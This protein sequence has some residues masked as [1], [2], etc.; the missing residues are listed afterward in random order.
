MKKIAFVLAAVVMCGGCVCE[1]NC[2][3]KK[4]PVA[5]HVV[6]I[7]VDGLGARWIPWDKMPNLSKL[8][9]D[10]LYAVGRDNYPTSSAINWA[11]V[12][13]G[14]VVEVHGYRNWNSE[15]PDVP[16]PSAAMDGAGCRAYSAKLG[17][18]ILLLTR[19]ASIHGAGLASAIIRTLSVSSSISAVRAAMLIHL[20]TLL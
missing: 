8:R 11:T 7:G 6:L 16:P 4:S 14:T 20:V 13:Y 19:P 1:K 2:E 18:K 15:K 10:G 3:T 17:V 5:K 9:Q 12:F